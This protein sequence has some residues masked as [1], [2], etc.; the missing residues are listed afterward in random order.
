MRLGMWEPSVN[1]LGPACCHSISL[2]DGFVT[3]V[4]SNHPGVRSVGTLTESLIMLDGPKRRRSLF[5]SLLRLHSGKIKHRVPRN[6]TEY[7]H[8]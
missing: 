8:G 3:V 5:V 7:L 4:C 2:A 6:R 1:G